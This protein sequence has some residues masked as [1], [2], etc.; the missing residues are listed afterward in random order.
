MIQT[1]K[2]VK[3]LHFDWSRLCKVYSAW[4]KNVR[5]SNLSWHW[6]VRQKLKKNWF[7][8]WKMTW[9]I[10]QIFSRVLESLKIETFIIS[11]IQIRK[12]LSLTFTTDFCVI[13]QTL[14]KNW[15]SRLKLTRGT[16]QSLTWALKN[17]KNLYFSQFAFDRNL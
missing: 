15:L 8:V 4:P 14:K 11:F 10:W 6:R 7:V 9:R 5:R 17:L 3:N 12:C 16:W 13:M 2:S 1:L